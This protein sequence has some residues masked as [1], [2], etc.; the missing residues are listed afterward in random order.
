MSDANFTLDARVSPTFLIIIIII[1]YI[2]L[3]SYSALYNYYVNVEP[4]R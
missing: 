2:V 1:I 4:T 3:F